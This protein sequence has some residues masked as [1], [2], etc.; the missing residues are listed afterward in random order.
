MKVFCKAIQLPNRETG[1]ELGEQRV[2][3]HLE[4]GK[5][6]TVMGMSCG[7]GSPGDV[8]L[9]LPDEYYV[10]D[11]PLCLFDI[12]DERP[13]RYWRTRKFGDQGLHLWPEEFYIEYFHDRLSDF[14][15]ELTAIYR[16]LRTRMEREFD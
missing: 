4:I 7:I 12:V 11:A 13:S 1:N 9:E 2:W 15:P 3:S 10:I 8:S 14:D 6:Y 16:E 5:L